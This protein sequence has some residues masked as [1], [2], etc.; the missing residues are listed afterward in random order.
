M[1]II[2]EKR[3][4]GFVFRNGTT[5]T[6]DNDAIGAWAT[7]LGPLGEGVYICMI[8]PYTFDDDSVVYWYDHKWTDEEVVVVKLS[9]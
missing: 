1:N 2:I 4:I 6:S 9:S 8:L 7:N 5:F 3:R